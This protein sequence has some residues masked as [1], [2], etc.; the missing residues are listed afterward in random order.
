MREIYILP[1]ALKSQSVE[2]VLLSG[3]CSELNAPA[4]LSSLLTQNSRLSGRIALPIF[5][6]AS[7]PL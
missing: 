3:K 4:L 2:R 7:L 1:F 5:G 6:V